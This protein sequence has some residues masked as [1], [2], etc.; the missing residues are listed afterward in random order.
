MF[1]I[2]MA[3][4]TP[5]EKIKEFTKSVNYELGA[6]IINKEN[7]QTDFAHAVLYL[8]ELIV[9]VE[10]LTNNKEKLRNCPDCNVTP[11]SK[12][13]NGCDVE[14]CSVCGTQKLS[15]KCKGH[16]TAFARWTGMWPGS[17]EVIILGIDLNTLYSSGIYK[18]IFIK[19]K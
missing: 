10:T 1:G 5:L 15:C 13:L 18:Y 11:G 7:Y 9:V 17:A 12:H 3:T 19:P 6:N 16:D 2:N 4:R 14:R 8:Q